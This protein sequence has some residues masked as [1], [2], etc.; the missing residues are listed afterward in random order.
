MLKLADDW[1]AASQYS[2]MMR[3]KFL[4]HFYRKYSVEG[5]YVF[6]DKSEC[7][8]LLQKELAVDTVAQSENGLS[9]CI[10]EKIEQWPGYERSNFALEVMTCTVPGRER[11]GWMHY[12]KADY[13]LYA[14]AFPDDKGLA[15]YLINF[16]KLKQWFW[17]LPRR[18]PDHT[19][20]TFNRT[21][22]EKVPIKDVRASVPTSRYHITN[23]GC[24]LIAVRSNL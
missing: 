5:R 22:F 12:A 18:Y 15:V 13:L 4:V 23:E 7:S 20:D 21:R 17:S 9:V 8:T 6:I 1:I 3:N 19:M 16:P 2:R 14:F 24:S 11:E 10:E